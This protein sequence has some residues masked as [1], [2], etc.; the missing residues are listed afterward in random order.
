MRCLQVD[1]KEGTV[2]I[3]QYAYQIRASI[4]L[5][6]TTIVVGNTGFLIFFEDYFNSL[7]AIKQVKLMQASLADTEIESKEA[8]DNYLNYVKNYNKIK[9][10]PQHLLVS[11]KKMEREMIKIVH[12]WKDDFMKNIEIFGLKDL[13]SFYE[14]NVFEPLAYAVGSEREDDI[15]LPK[16][17]VLTHQSPVNF[18]QKAVWLMPSQFYSSDIFV[19][20]ADTTIQHQNNTAYFIKAFTLPNI[21][22]LTATELNSIKNQLNESLIQFNED[23]DE[24]ATA[25]YLGNGKNVFETKVLPKLAQVSDII[26]S[27]ILLQHT[28]R[29]H[30]Q[31]LT[32][33]VYLGEVDKPTFLKW[34][35]QQ[36]VIDDD[37]YKQTIEA[38]NNTEAHTV[39]IML[40]VATENLEFYD[41][42]NNEIIEEPKIIAVKKSINVD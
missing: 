27:N 14:K 31:Q 36:N 15:F 1:S 17:K 33:T 38:Y 10:P 19:Q 9:H 42:N 35:L 3:L 24:W 22:L 21:N 11:F 8:F 4:L 29:I 7:N 23:V 28:N 30:Q 41:K 6:Q 16:I 20:E 40:F 13:F 26:E 5:S 2:D 34:H 39:P 12:N 18:A 25:C 32:H 37:E